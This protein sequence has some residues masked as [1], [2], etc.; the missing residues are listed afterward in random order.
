MGC[1]E[2][3]A[4]V[5]V[6]VELIVVV[7]YYLGEVSPRRLHGDATSRDTSG[8]VRV[9]A[10]EVVGVDLRHHPP[11]ICKTTLLYLK[12]RPADRVVLWWKAMQD[13]VLV[14]AVRW[15]LLRCDGMKSVAAPVLLV[16]KIIGIFIWP[17]FHRFQFPVRRSQG[18]AR[19]AVALLA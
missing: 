19:G 11:N 13:H 9:G 6:V 16:E 5:L 1:F 7:T 3:G 17:Y 2:V 10:G 15:A 8:R 18:L 12:V 4:V 14:P